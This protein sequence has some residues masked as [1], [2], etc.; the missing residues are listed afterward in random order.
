[1]YIYI[2]CEYILGGCTFAL[3]CKNTILC[4][5]PSYVRS[6][7]TA[8]EPAERC[9]VGRLSASSYIWPLRQRIGN[10][11]EGTNRQGNIIAL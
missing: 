5:Y 6:R 8:Y 10:P 7:V 2:F 9:P 3:W 1:M 11:H 4:T